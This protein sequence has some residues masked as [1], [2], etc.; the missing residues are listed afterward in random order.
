[1]N[2][3]QLAFHPYFALERYM[4]VTVSK[5]FVKVLVWYFLFVTSFA[6]SFYFLFHMPNDAEVSWHIFLAI[7]IVGLVDKISKQSTGQPCLCKCGGIGYEDN[8]DGLHR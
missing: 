8:R 2:P 6:L 4:F 5:N 7:I 1:M 3:K